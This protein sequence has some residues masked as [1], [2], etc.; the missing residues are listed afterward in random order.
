MFELFLDR[1]NMMYSSAYFEHSEQSL[2]DA[3]L[4]RL[5]RICEALELSADD[6]LLEIGTGWGGMAIH[7]ATT[8][9]CRVTTTTISQE[10]RSYAER[11]VRQA[12]LEDRVEVLG[13]DYRDLRGRYDK[14]VSVEMIEAVGWEWFDTYFRR[15]SRLLK[16]QGL[17]FL[18]AIVVDDRAYEIEKASRTLASELIFPGGCLPSPATI[19]RSIAEQTDLRPVWLEDISP[20]YVRTLAEWRRRFVAA[21][22]QLGE[23]GY[24]ERFRRLWEIWLA[25]S[26]AGFA[27]ARIADLQLLYAKP[28]WRGAVTIES[29]RADSDGADPGIPNARSAFAR[30]GP[31]GGRPNG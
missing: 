4:A 31:V 2:E 30:G 3:Q 18:Q 23:L 25:T 22:P 28:Q 11:R 20:S 27:E 24:D 13:A 5:G 29:A 9:G 26:E 7:A 10:Q 14:L 15:C 6:H 8:R 12:G 1:E 16:P 21:A 17:F 19:A